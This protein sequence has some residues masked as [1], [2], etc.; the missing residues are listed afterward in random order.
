M[1]GIHRVL[2]ETILPVYF[3]TGSFELYNGN[4]IPNRRYISLMIKTIIVIVW[5]CLIK[6]VSFGY[7]LSVTITTHG[8]GVS[9]TDVGDIIVS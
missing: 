3:S 8:G 6:R 1:W 2:I 9:E 5:R 4:I 7:D